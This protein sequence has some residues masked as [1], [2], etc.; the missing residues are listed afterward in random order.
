MVQHHCCQIT[1]FV[2]LQ[3]LSDTG[4]LQCQS[5]TCNTKYVGWGEET[6]GSWNN[7]TITDSRYVCLCARLS[8]LYLM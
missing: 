2:K 7:S 1:A 4:L 6:F 3:L 5:F 8:E